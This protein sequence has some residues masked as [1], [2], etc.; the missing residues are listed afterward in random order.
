MAALA[1]IRAKHDAIKALT[2]NLD[3]KVVQ[4]GLI[5]DDTLHYYGSLLGVCG[6][7]PGSLE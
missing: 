2:L 1:P 7:R 4:W 6:K 5:D 3:D